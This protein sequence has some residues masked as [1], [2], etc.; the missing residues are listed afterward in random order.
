MCSLVARMKSHIHKC[1][2]ININKDE[3]CDQFE[4]DDTDN[5]NEL[6]EVTEMNL[7]EK[8]ICKYIHI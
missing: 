8:Q 1:N 2:S 7:T 6:L 5:N 3:I 4:I